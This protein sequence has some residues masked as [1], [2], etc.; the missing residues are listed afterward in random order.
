MKAKRR[1]AQKRRKKKKERKK[2]RFEVKY[3]IQREFM[4]VRSATEPQ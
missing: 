4:S 1:V 2:S 3:A